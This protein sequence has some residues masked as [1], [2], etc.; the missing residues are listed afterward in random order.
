MQQITNP[1]GNDLTEITKLLQSIYKQ[2]NDAHRETT[3][4]VIEKDNYSTLMILVNYYQVEARTEI[5]LELLKIFVFLF[6]ISDTINRQLTPTV[7]TVEF[8]RDLRYGG[9]SQN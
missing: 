5:R 3:L 6:S 8:G 4:A 7:I 1:I 2:I 9:N